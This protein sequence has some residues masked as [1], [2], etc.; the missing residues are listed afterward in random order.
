MATNNPRSNG[1]GRFDPRKHRF[2]TFAAVLG[3]IAVLAIAVGLIWM[4]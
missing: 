4:G 1:N 2:A 3:V